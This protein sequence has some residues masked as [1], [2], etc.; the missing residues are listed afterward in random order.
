MQVPAPQQRA[1]SVVPSSRTCYAK[2][3]PLSKAFAVAKTLE[4]FCSENKYQ[5]RSFRFQ[6]EHAEY[7]YD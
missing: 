6:T 5:S 1:P 7:P 4:I 3:P 2:Y